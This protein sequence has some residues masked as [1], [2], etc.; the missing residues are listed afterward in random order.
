[1]KKLFTI[2]LTI[3]FILCLGVNVF[4]ACVYFLKPDVLVASTFELSPM[5][6][7]DGTDTRCFLE[8]KYY[9][10]ANDDGLEMFDVKYN[11]FID[12]T[13]KEFYSQGMQYVANSKT[14]DISFVYKVNELYAPTIDKT[15]QT[16]WLYH[17]Y[18]KSF[19]GSMYSGKTSKLYNYMSGDDYKT[20][21]ISSNPINDDTYFTIDLGD[22]GIYKMSFK[23]LSGVD[24]DKY[25]DVTEDAYSEWKGLWSDFYNYYYYQ[26]LDVNYFN[27]LLYNSVKDMPSGTNHNVLFEFG[28]MFNYYKYDEE[29]QQYLEQNVQGE[30]LEKVIDVVQS[31]FVINVEIIDDGAKTARDSLFNSVGGNANFNMTGEYVSS[32]YFYGRDVIS[33]NEYDFDYHKLD[34]GTYE[35]KLKEEFMSFYQ[36]YKDD[37]VLEIEINSDTLSTKNINDW[38]FAEDSGLKNFVVSK[39]VSITHFGREIIESEVKYAI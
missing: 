8:L 23:S 4:Y 30:M 36:N 17:Y 3:V 6:N 31:Y 9:K 12:E 35:L 32:D 25:Y 16:L 24:K 19:Y 20:T 15:G 11:Y 14:E 26:V 29:K 1:M 5:T 37:I 28:D 34:D 13:K 21:S 33:V 38:H 7:S 18:N 10:N 27:Y 39:C 22:S 2:F